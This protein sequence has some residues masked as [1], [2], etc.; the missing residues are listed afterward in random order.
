MKQM[1]YWFA[2]FEQFSDGEN[3]LVH[4]TR[5]HD[6]NIHTWPTKA[7]ALKDLR[8]HFATRENRMRLCSAKFRRG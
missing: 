7:A 3:K 5:D 6:D 8:K 4:I 1:T 2:V